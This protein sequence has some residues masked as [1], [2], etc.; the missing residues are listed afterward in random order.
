MYYKAGLTT[1]RKGGEQR[2]ERCGHGNEGEPARACLNKLERS[3][4]GWSA[5]QST[6]T[7]NLPAQRKPAVRDSEEGVF[8]KI[9]I[10][11]GFLCP[12]V[13]VRLSGQLNLEG[14]F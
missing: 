12:R 3:T 10:N 2:R 6:N 4:I 7:G 13:V 5:L 14:N 9:Y 11:R 1:S 8:L